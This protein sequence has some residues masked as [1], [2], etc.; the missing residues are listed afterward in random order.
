MVSLR[1]M[2]F[3]LF[4]IALGALPL[5]VQGQPAPGDIN[6]TRQG[7]RRFVF[8]DQHTL[9]LAALKPAEVIG[10]SSMYPVSHHADTHAQVTIRRDRL[11]IGSDTET[12]TTVWFGGFNPFATYTLEVASS[13]GEGAVGFEFADAGNATRFAVMVLYRGQ[14]IVDVKLAIREAGKVVA[15]ESIATNIAPGAML[16]GKIILQ[17][18]GSGLTVYTQHDGLPRPIAQSDFSQLLDLRAKRYLQTFQSRVSVHLKEGAV[19]IEG[20]AAALTGGMGL[21]DIRA[22]TYED[23]SPLLDRGRLWYTMTIRGRALPHHVQGVFSMDPTVFDLRF[24]GVIVFDRADGILR[25]EVAS[26]IFYDRRDSV[27]RGITT[28]FSAYADPKEHKQLLAVESMKDPRFGFSVMQ[29]EPFGV[30]GDIEDPHILYDAEAGKWRILT[31]EHIDGYK[32]V[33]LESTSW[34]KGYRR[35]AGPVAHNS[36]GTSIQ[37]IGGVPYCFS[38]SSEREIFIYSYPDLQEVGTL[39]MDLPP[40]DGESGTRVWPNVVELPPGYPFR[41]VALMMDRF[42]YPG[43]VGPNWT[44]GALYLYHGYVN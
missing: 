8:D 1:R 35:I 30:V 25:N 10:M 32:A 34:N 24:E 38:G 15:S 44:Y 27:W 14:H 19:A 37:R 31:C 28:G 4:L 5:F 40:W 7:V 11:L 2:A 43:L 17:L 20:A 21:A 26:H 39:K 6:F 12:R 22:M 13:E 9:P 16:Q 33:L 23:G 29:A 36:T 3:R 41:Y 42:N 18:L